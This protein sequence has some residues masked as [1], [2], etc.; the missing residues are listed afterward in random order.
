[1][2]VCLFSEISPNDY[3]FFTND[4]TPDHLADLTVAKC[5]EHLVIVSKLHGVLLLRLTITNKAIS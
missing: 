2:L 5:R 4:S 1:M 3:S